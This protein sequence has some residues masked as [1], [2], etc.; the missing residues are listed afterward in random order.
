V[1]PEE[2]ALQ[3]TRALRN[4]LKDAIMT[5][6]WAGVPSPIATFYQEK[7]KGLSKKFEIINVGVVID[8]SAIRNAG[9]DVTLPITVH[10]SFR[11]K[12]QERVNSLPIPSTWRWQESGGTMTLVNVQ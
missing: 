6:S 10:V 9:P 2:M 1:N 5:A 11:Q 3:S 12:G 4:K 7:V 8:D